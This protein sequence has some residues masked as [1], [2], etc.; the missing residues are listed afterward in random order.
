M[1]QRIFQN[2]TE[3]V[4]ENTDDMEDSVHET[5]VSKVLAIEAEVQLVQKLIIFLCRHK[6]ME[7]HF[8]LGKVMSPLSQNYNSLA[9][10]FSTL[11]SIH[12]QMRPT[13]DISVQFFGIDWTHLFRISCNLIQI[14][15]DVMQRLKERGDDPNFEIDLILP[16]Y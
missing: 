13:F 2:L 15:N 3:Q 16:R 1:K 5:F 11:T 6:P 4:Q 9:K 10:T 14:T 8:R 12:D 7:R